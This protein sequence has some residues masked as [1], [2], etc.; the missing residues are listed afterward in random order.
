MYM[1]AAKVPI[2]VMVQPLILPVDLMVGESQ[3]QPQVIVLQAEVALI[4]VL[5]LHLFMH[6]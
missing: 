5:N 3:Q 1:L 4:F 2:M 6:V